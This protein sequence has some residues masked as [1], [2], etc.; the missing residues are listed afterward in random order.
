M[1]Y[2]FQYRNRGHANNCLRFVFESIGGLWALC[3]ILK[4][5]RVSILGDEEKYFEEVAKLKIE[6][7]YFKE[8]PTVSVS[9]LN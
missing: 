5:F 8:K 2:N 3:K 6:V 7:V 1:I 4:H 9:H